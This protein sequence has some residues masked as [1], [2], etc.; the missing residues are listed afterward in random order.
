MDN[1][2]LVVN[3]KI[4][5]DEPTQKFLETLLRNVPIA[6]PVS[7]D[8][9]IDLVQLENRIMENVTKID[10]G[11][12]LLE[13]TLTK[14]EDIEI[15]ASD[16]QVETMPKN[17]EEKMQNVNDAPFEES[18][19]PQK[20][21]EP[22]ENKDISEAK[23]PTVTLEILRAELADVMKKGDKD[24]VRQMLG[25]VSAKKLSDVEPKSYKLLDELIKSWKINGEKAF[26]K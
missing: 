6:I 21:I 9:A 19:E 23:E 17:N 2:N 12:K 16:V 3:V 22:K 24:V 18:T 14:N 8:K 7:K 15:Q 20:D 1:L 5:F 13:E 10:A 4:G 26:T 11:M 25:Y